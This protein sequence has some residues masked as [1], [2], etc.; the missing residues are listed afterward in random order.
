MSAP[1]LFHKKKSKYFFVIKHI[2][3]NVSIISFE[4]VIKIN[5]KNIYTYEYAR[6]NVNIYHYLLLKD[7]CYKDIYIYIMSGFNLKGWC[8]FKIKLYVVNSFVFD[9]KDESQIFEI[10]KVII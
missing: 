8:L 10:C 2:Y 9:R 7:R 3:L 4:V 6:Q 5:F 1:V